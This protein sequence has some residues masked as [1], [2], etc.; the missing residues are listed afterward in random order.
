MQWNLGLG[1]INIYNMKSE[2]KIRERVASFDDL[3]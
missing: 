1:A 2:F 3:K